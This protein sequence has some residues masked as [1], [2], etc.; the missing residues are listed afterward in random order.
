MWRGRG[1][2][3]GA[4]QSAL[5]SYASRRRAAQLSCARECRRGAAQRSART[6]RRDVSGH[7]HCGLAGA[8]AFQHLRAQCQTGALP[9]V[10]CAV[11]SAA[12]T[13]RRLAGSLPLQPAPPGPLGRK[14]GTGASC[15]RLIEHGRRRAGL[16]HL[17]ALALPHVPVQRLQCG[18]HHTYKHSF[19]LHSLALCPGAFPLLLKPF[20]HALPSQ[21]ASCSLARSKQARRQCTERPMHC[22]GG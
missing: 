16:A 17:L 14:Q 6:A 1:G 15:Q 18:K 12:W 9:A 4:A 11:H 10:R 2:G 20:A 13:P 8:E 3:K 21:T 7:Q 22:W 5:P 19:S